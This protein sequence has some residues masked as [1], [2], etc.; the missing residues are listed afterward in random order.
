MS[1]AADKCCRSRLGSGRVSGRHPLPQRSRSGGVGVCRGG[2][3]KSGTETEKTK[4]EIA[5]VG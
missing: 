1:A 2:R 4:E 3:V 5:G